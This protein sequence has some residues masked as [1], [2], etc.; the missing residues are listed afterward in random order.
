MNYQVQRKSNPLT[1]FAV[2]S[3]T[4]RNFSVKFDMFMW[5][6]YLNLNTE[7]NL[8]IFKYDEVIN[9]LA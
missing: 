7:R 4:A 5:L 8:I 9:I 2:F 6:S 1:L 3:A